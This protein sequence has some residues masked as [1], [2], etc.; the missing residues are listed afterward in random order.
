MQ[1]VYNMDSVFLLFLDT[2]YL[3]V[4]GRNFNLG[5]NTEAH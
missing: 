5:A 3:V 2:V 4:F 1:V